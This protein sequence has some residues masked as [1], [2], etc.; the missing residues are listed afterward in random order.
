MEINV[1]KYDIPLKVP[2]WYFDLFI[3]RAKGYI[4]E[5]VFHNKKYYVDY[6]SNPEFCSQFDIQLLLELVHKAII[7]NLPDD[8]ILNHPILIDYP[9]FYFPLWSLINSLKI[10]ETNREIK[11]AYFYND[12][13]SNFRDNIIKVA[14]DNYS[15]IKLKKDIFLNHYKE[16]DEICED[17]NIKFRIDFNRAAKFEELSS[18]FSNIKPSTIDFIEEP[19]SNSRDFKRFKQLFDFQIALDETLIQNKLDEIDDEDYDIL[20][21]KPGLVFDFENII[22]NG[23]NKSKRIILSSAYESSVGISHIIRLAV[24]H[25]LNDYMGLDTTKFFAEDF[26]DLL[27]YKS[28]SISL[29]SN[30]KIDY[31]KLKRII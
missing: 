16:L 29:N 3:D 8:S 21:I 11:L 6:P 9:Q 5:C 19:F 12:T 10:D 14:N 13:N 30:F 23:L 17:L 20:S 26:S 28:N 7:S 4:F 25:N 18:I 31:S 2:A 27:I 24:K 1:Y 22:L 15:I